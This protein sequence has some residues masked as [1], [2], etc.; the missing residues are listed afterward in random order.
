MDGDEIAAG[1]LT[2][3][4]CTIIVA[5]QN[6]AAIRFDENGIRAMGRT[7]RGVRA[8]KFRGDDHVVGATKIFDDSMSIL[9]VTDKGMG[10]RCAVSSYR[11]QKRGG[12]GLKNYPVSEEKGNVIGIRTLGPD[13]DVILISLD[14][15]IIRIRANDLRIMGRPAS[16]VRVM[17]LG[18]DDKLVAFTRTP[19]DDDEQTE[20]VESA[21]EEEVEASLAEE[22]TE[23]VEPDDDTSD[24]EDTEEDNSDE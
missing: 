11:L 8:I 21:S 14:G 2:E 4:D 24:D 1:F 16:G 20:E 19:H 13:D 7:A 22:A 6:G 18:E 12:L 5:T 23:A 3:G 10:R 15:I 9:T 17:R